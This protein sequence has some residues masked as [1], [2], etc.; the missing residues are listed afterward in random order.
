MFHAVH[1]R[2]R[3]S[4]TTLTAIAVAASL[5]IAGAGAPA[6]LE[7]SDDGTPRQKAL[8]GSWVET[9]T[10]PPEAGRLPLKSL[11]SFHADGTITCSDQGSVTLE[12]ASVFTSCH[13]AWRH[14]EKGRFAYTAFELISD[15]SGNHVGFLKVRGIYI[16]S[17]TGNDY[18]GNTFAEIFD[19]TGTVLY[20]VS[21]ANAGRRIQVEL[22]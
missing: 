13:G 3:A 22:P 18:T 7:A 8:V 20:S 10:F 2:R 5:L 14:L 16:V 6:G 19:T 15:L 21:V 1:S 17:P 12:P 9:V 4:A 11:S